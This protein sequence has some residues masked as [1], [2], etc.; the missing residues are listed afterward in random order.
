MVTTLTGLAV[1]T[2]MVFFCPP[3]LSDLMQ[4]TEMPT[5]FKFLLIGAVLIG[6]LLSVTGEQHIFPWFTQILKLRT[7]K[8]QEGAK[9]K[10]Y[11]AIGEQMRF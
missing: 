2:Y 6:F 5:S 9:R 4:L 10:K 3:W 11:K 7:A 8:L 1:S